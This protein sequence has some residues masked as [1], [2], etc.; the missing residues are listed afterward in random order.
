MPQACAA[1]GI[2]DVRDQ[3]E[4]LNRM[5]AAGIPLAEVVN[6]DILCEGK[7][8]TVPKI[9]F[10]VPDWSTFSIQAPPPV[11]V[12][13]K[14]QYDPPYPVRMMNIY[15]LMVPTIQI[16]PIFEN[17]LDEIKKN[18]RI[19][20]PL[21]C[22][23][24][25]IVDVRHQIDKLNRK[26]LDATRVVSLDIMDRNMVQ[27][28]PT[29]S[30]EGFPAWIYDIEEELVLPACKAILLKLQEVGAQGMWESFK[31]VVLGL[32]PTP[33]TEVVKASA[34]SPDLVEMKAKLVLSVPAFQTPGLG[35]FSRL[36]RLLPTLAQPSASW[37]SATRSRSSTAWR[38]RGS[39]SQRLWIATSSARDRSSR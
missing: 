21:A 20:L 2:K 13:R 31:V 16:G 15:G 26:G 12:S 28:M 7:V 8:E 33:T 6:L 32:P 34:P 27:D 10:V 11:P 22:K 35:V 5:A 23:V 14:G 1:I 36:A 9:K 24:I 38:L 25:G 18:V 19:V 39:R 4:K 17:N 29:L 3:V 37:P 30:L